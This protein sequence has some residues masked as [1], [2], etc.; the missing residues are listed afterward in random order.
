MYIFSV[1]RATLPQN[2]CRWYIAYAKTV[3][4]KVDKPQSR[5]ARL[6]LGR[7]HRKPRS[8]PN[9]LTV[10][11]LDTYITKDDENVTSFFSYFSFWCRALDLAGPPFSF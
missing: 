2:R 5:S 11:L 10:R 9:R 6:W 7:A 8:W 4:K 3:A 1:Q